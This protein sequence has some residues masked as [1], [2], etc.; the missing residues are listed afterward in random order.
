MLI[1]SEFR[2][3][4]TRALALTMVLLSGLT[5]CSSSDDDTATADDDSARVS[6]APSS[7][8]DDDAADSAASAD[9]T[10]ADAET[11]TAAVVEDPCAPGA[12]EPTLVTVGLQTGRHGMTTGYWIAMAEEFG[13]FEEVNIEIDDVAASSATDLLNGLTAGE[14]E[15][16][17]MGSAGMISA[18]QGAD[19]IAVAGAVNSSIWE[20]ISAS[21]FQTWDDLRGATIGVSNVNGVN[22]HAFR[23]MAELAGLDPETDLE[24]IQAGATAEAFLALRGGQIDALPAAPPTNFLAADE[25][26]TTYGF[27]PEGTDVPKISALQILTSREWAESNDVVLTCFMRGILR[28]IDFVEDPSNRDE[29]IEVSLPIL[30]GGSSTIE[31]EHLIQAIELYI[32]DPLLAPYVWHD[33]HLPEDSFQAA[34]DIFIAGGSIEADNAIAYED[35]VD[36]TYIDAA[37]AAEER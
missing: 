5:A 3:T 1:P 12:S 26:F 8:G 34:M 22:A 10:A 33:L 23:Q 20:P 2:F 9:D 31:D 27:A 7:T 11:D 13:Y 28:L 37:I 4:W 6:E 21:E 15:V 29:V 25:G 17:V 14:L 36:H 35:F 19:M 18:S 24:F 30:Q 16:N 32:D